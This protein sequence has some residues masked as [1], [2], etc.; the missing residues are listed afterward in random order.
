M[1]Y[2]KDVDKL[3]SNF[4][5]LENDI[6]IDIIRRIRKTGKITS[7]AD[8]QLNKLK[9]LG[10]TNEE[11]E[12]LIKDRLNLTYPQVFELYDKAIQEDYTRD[13]SLYEKV[14]ADYIPYRNN[15]EIQRQVEALKVQTSD[16]FKNFTKTTGFITILENGQYTFLNTKNYIYSQLDRALLDISSGAFS[17]DEVLKRITRDL[18]NRGLCH[19]EYESGRINRID[20]VVRRSVMT[21]LSQMQGNIADMNA[22]M[23]GTEYFEV[24][25]HMGARPTHAIWQGKIYTKKELVE[26]CGLGSAG[27]LKG[28]NCYHNYSP[29]IKGVSVP[30]YTDKELKLLNKRDKATVDYKG[31]KY[32]T[33]EATQ[34][35]RQ[36]ERSARSQRLKI[37]ALKEG[38]ANNI[39]IEKAKYRY[40]NI[41]KDYREFSKIVNLPTQTSRIYNDGLGRVL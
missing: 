28:V 10:K 12:K 35:Q 1:K 27:G 41:L 23:L 36:Y 19:I 32:T 16:T 18:T 2:D 29:F 5:Q 24:D 15:L 4:Q 30:R 40:K 20:T 14:S 38:G 11:I 8:Y 17:Y 34:R 26:V 9:I 31:K 37:R 13:E 7:T 33:Y 3:V 25:W 39:D 6:I 22:E 21:G